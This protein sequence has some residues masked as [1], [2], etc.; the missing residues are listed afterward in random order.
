MKQRRAAGIFGLAG[1]IIFAAGAVISI[2]TFERG[3]YSPANCFVTELGL[4]TGG[5]MTAS[6]ALVFNIGLILSGVLLGL[7]MFIYGFSNEAP[8]HTAVS[9]FG[10]LS[11][12]LMAAQ[13]LFS[14]NFYTY[15][16]I[17]A[18]AFFVSLVIMCVLYIIAKK[19]SGNRLSMSAQTIAS[20]LTG[21]AAALSAGYMITGGM[22]Q[23]FEEDA[24][25]IGR[26]NLIPFAVIGWAAYAMFLFFIA[27]YSIRILFEKEKPIKEEPA[28]SASGG[29]K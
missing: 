6:S 21:A 29:S 20:F 3:I 23:V 15:H 14:L 18:S 27:A 9:F 17:L 16:Y 12:I 25:G 19:F 28:F 26:V 13:G 2:L 1:V 10:V 24:L 8:L 22:A 7:F 4:Y 11:G 5:F